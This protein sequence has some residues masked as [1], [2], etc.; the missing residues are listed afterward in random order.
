[1]LPS[2]VCFVLVVEGSSSPFVLRLQTVFAE[3]VSCHVRS[4]DSILTHVQPIF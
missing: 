1:M 3:T 4:L 2:R